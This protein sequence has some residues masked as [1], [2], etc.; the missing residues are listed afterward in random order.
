MW[1]RRPFNASS[2]VERTREFGIRMALGATSAD[3]VRMVATSGISLALVGAVVGGVLSVLAVPLVR[4]Y[5][6]GVEP[7]DPATYVSVVAFLVAVAH[8]DSSYSQLNS[9]SLGI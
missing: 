2:I 4:S 8:V 9:Y 3:T 7:G 6:W 5:L 1:A